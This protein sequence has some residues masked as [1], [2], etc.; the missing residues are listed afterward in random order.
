MQLPAVLTGLG[1]VLLA[2]VVVLSPVA[3]LVRDAR[4]TVAPSTEAARTLRH[5]AMPAAVAAAVLLLGLV[6]VVAGVVG[7]GLV[8]PRALLS[9]RLVAALP[10]AAALAFL[11][12]HAVGEVTYPR[13]TGDVRTAGLQVRTPADVAPAHLWRAVHAWAALLGVALALGAATATGPRHLD[14]V[15]EGW[16]SRGQPYPGSWYGVPLAAGTVLVLLATHAVLHLVA[17]RSA[18]SGVD[19][20]WDL[21]LRR[22]TAAR[23]LR[24]VQLIL[25]LTL[26]GV[27]LLASVGL[28]LAAWPMPTLGEGSA[29]PAL[30]ATGWCLAVAA[31]V[32][33]VTG[34]VLAVRRGTPRVDA[35]ATGAPVHA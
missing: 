6:L 12:V 16:I 19:H 1:T 23:V 24:G 7:I 32:V 31:L 22:R 18:V 30:A 20:A 2:T 4:R 13:P 11:L 21:A 27:L 26:A 35:A 8:G 15:V 25:A 9:G 17:A 28:R 3:V 29:S 34:V 10:L 14:R 5:A 33:A